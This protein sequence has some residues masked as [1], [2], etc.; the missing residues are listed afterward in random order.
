MPLLPMPSPM[1]PIGH[2]A[3][4]GDGALGLVVGGGVGG[5]WE[6]MKAERKEG[7]L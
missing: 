5:D 4:G 2:G 3:P 6:G 1:L 7:G